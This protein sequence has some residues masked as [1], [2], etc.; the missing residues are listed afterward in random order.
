VLDRG[1]EYQRLGEARVRRADLR[2]V[3]ATNRRVED[4]KHDLAARF[5]LR[6]EVP[7]LAAR[8]EDVP[9]LLRHLLR[10]AGATHPEVARRFFVEPG[11]GLA[12]EA[13]LSPDLVDRL[14]R[15]PFPHNLREL[16]QILW[17]ALGESRGDTIE[18]TPGVQQR[19]AQPAPTRPSGG[20]E[21][22]REQIEACLGLHHGNITRAA[23][24]LGLKNRFVLY[25]LMKRLGVDPGSD[26]PSSDEPG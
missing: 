11:P 4:L 24:A 10:R 18:L 23:R 15:H 13:R 17:Q 19:L 20:A 2:V 5:T 6:I 3:A 8:L 9:L 16:D 26:E 21:P 22:S 12:P 7:P 25:R 14:V 1:G